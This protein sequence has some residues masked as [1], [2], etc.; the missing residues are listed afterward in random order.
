MQRIV[1]PILTLGGYGHGFRSE[2]LELKDGQ[3]TEIAFMAKGKIDHAITVVKMEDY[4]K[5][6]L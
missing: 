1:N 4:W 6:C 2:I 5:Y 3:W